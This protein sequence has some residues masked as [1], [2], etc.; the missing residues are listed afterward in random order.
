M[1]SLW[2]ALLLLAAIPVIQRVHSSQTGDTHH[3]LS[4]LVGSM[5]QR[6][7]RSYARTK[8]LF[9]FRT[10]R[11]GKITESV[12]EYVKGASIGANGGRLRSHGDSP[13][14]REASF[15]LSR[16]MV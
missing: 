12:L 3:R 14:T 9:E 13:I 16:A 4:A 11:Y 6:M 2:V 7:R 1:I 5:E 15:T 10:T 8:R